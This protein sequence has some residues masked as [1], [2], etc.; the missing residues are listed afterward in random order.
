[1][2]PM[3]ARFVTPLTFQALSG[4]AVLTE[5]FRSR[6]GRGLWSS[7]SGPLGQSGDR[8]S[9]DGG[10]AGQ[11]RHGFC[12][13]AVTTTVVAARAPL[14]LCP[15][16][17]TAM[18]EN[19]RVQANLEA[20]RRNPRV[21]LVGPATGVLADGDVGEGRLAEVPDIVN[22]ALARL[23]PSDLMGVKVLVTAGPTRE[24][25]DPVRFISNPSTGRMGYA[26]AQGAALR[27]ARVTLV[28]GPVEL[29]P[30][31]G[32]DVVRVETAEEMLV[33]CTAALPSVKLVIAAAA[34][35]DYRPRDVAAQKKK[36]GVPGQPEDENVVLV[37][38][39]D[40]LQ[41]LSRMSNAGPRPVFVGFAAE[42]E[43]L[44][45]NAHRKLEGKGLD[46][47]VANQVGKTGTGFASDDNEVTFVSVAK[48]EALPKM[49]KRALADKILDWAV[50]KLK[51]S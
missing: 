45:L 5:L 8:C 21:S 37:R 7:R 43:N 22:A 20:L 33:A 12:D 32:V 19:P 18:W 48:D 41:T 2:T 14:L 23:A 6:A 31:M 16:M 47:V 40:V 29:P 35:A 17:N 1:M 51:K 36:K 30:P 11:D 15:A 42:T 27:G 13:D 28:S 50:A 9:C 49:S 3:A 25:L 10:L 38:T 24:R 46:L 44:L 39:P 26:I 34:V 4:E